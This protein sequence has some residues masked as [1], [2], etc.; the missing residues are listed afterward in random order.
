M[1]ASRYLS[2]VL[3]FALGLILTINPVSSAADDDWESLQSGIQGRLVERRC[4][5]HPHRRLRTQTLRPWPL[6]ARHSSTAVRRR[7]SQ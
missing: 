1:P 5:R 2:S 4:G 7:P 6:P 3:L